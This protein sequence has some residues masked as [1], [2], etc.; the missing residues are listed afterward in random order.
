MGPVATKMQLEK[1]ESMVARAVSEGAKVLTGGARPALA[2][3]PEG[4][5]YQPTVVH[6]LSKDNFLMR[7]EVFGPVLAV[8]PFTDEAEVLALANDTE[9]GLAAGVWT[10]DISRAHKMARAIESGTVW[11]NTYRALTFN[12]PFG[13]YKASGI[14]REFGA[15]GL[16]EYVE[17]KAIAA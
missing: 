12:S 15:A 13:G 3:F 5:F 1:D 9:F 14:G 11:I 16:E 2:E 4:Y 8:T 10:R 6:Q 7:N 17:L